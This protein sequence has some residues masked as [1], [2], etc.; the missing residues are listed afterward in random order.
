MNLF[1]DSQGDNPPQ[2]GQVGD[3]NNQPR[4]VT[5]HGGGNNVG[6]GAVVWECVYPM[7]AVKDA[8]GNPQLPTYAPE[9]PNA[10]PCTDGINAA[11]GRIHGDGPGTLYFDEMATVRDILTKS[12]IAPGGKANPDFKLYILGYAHFFNTNDNY[13][14]GVSFAPLGLGGA[15]PGNPPKLSVALRTAFN[16]AITDVNTILAQVATDINKELGGNWAKFIDISPAFNGHRFCEDVH[17]TFDQWR[18][19][20]VWLWNANP[21]V[22]D[23]PSG[24]INAMHQWIDQGTMADGTV[25]SLPDGFAVTGGSEGGIGQIGWQYRPFHPKIGGTTSVAENIVANALADKIPGVVGAA[26]ATVTTSSAP[27]PTCAAPSQTTSPYA[28]GGQCATC[29]EDGCGSCAPGCCANG[30]C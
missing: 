15:A 21:P 6:F 7:P 16:T 23:P 8:N 2:M 28:A 30:T 25:W 14:K 19:E 17:N 13:C 9:Y 22:L 26:A 29:N 24:D 18:N 4:M 12:Q 20:D 11:N 27:T 3:P 10:G 5:Y 1:Q